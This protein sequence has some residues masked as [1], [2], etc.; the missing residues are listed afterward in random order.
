VDHET[1]PEDTADPEL[2][3]YRTRPVSSVMRRHWISASPSASVVEI[4]QVMRVARVR[5]LPVESEGVL[6][7][8]VHLRRILA[9]TLAQLR[10]D[11]AGPPIAAQR[12]DDVMDPR[13][14]T[15]RPGEAVGPAAL[16]MHDAGIGCLPVVGEKGRLVGL[17]VES[18]LL[19]A[20]Y[21]DRSVP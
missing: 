6:V 3:E 5:Q 10:D 20:V 15:A 18:D 9:S 4:E 19:R 8:L 2:R 1:R 13:P 12:V 21:E 16:R 7:G 11:A 17:V 14:P